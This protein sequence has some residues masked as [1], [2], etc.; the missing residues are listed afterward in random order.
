MDLYEAIKG[1]RSI[2]RFKPDPVPKEVLERIF[3]MA[4]WAPSG[5]NFQNWHFVVVTGERKEALVELASKSYDYIEPVLREVFADKPPV[6]E[7]IKK[8]FKRLGGAPVVALAYYKH[9]KER[10]ETSIQS[11]AAAIQNLLLSAYAEGLGACWMTGPVHVAG[12]INEFLNIH[13]KVLV[14][15][16]PIGYPDESP[17]FP[18]RKPNRVVYEGF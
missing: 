2:R 12:Q 9:S 5:M 10:P 11:V 8:F 4:T 18:K 14:A 1:R 13:D 15:I 7:S 17:P 6:V 16:I 3:E